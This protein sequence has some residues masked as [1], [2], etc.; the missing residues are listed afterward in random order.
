MFGRDKLE[1][2]L[3]SHLPHAFFQEVFYLGNAGIFGF[4]ICVQQGVQN[5]GELGCDLFFR[6]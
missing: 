6:I 3:F 4:R 5:I 2:S 1:Q